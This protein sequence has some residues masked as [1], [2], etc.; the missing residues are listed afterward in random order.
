[1]AKQS[2]QNQNPYL[3]LYNR[4]RAVPKTAQKDF[5]NGQFSGTDIN[6]MWR[7]KTLTEQFG[8]AGVGWYYEIV[9]HWSEPQLQEVAVHVRINLYIRDP[10]TKEW[11]KPI[12]GLGGSSSVSVGKKGARCTDEAYKMAL[13]DAIS[14]AC[15]ALGIG[16]DVY[17]DKDE[18]K[19][20]QYEHQVQI[21]P[22]PQ[23]QPRLQQPYYQQAP[24]PA[25]PQQ[26]PPQQA[27][28][29]K[30]SAH[31]PICAYTPQQAIDDLQRAVSTDDLAAKWQFWKAYFS[32]NAEVIAVIHHHP[33]N[34]N[35]KK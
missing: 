18:T 17:W 29:A 20:S 7:I 34:P 28:P 5:T 16:A 4:V 13:T 26:M 30:Q 32:K 33:F 19:Y 35:N 11:S 6:P 22:A 14:V 9:E 25:P 2:N 21:P 3:E 1:M 24:N 8:V 15:K 27:A 10:E 31:P 23:P 12:Q